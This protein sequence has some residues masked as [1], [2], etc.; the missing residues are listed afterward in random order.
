MGKL[1]SRLS[2][3]GRLHGNRLSSI[4]LGTIL[5]GNFQFVMAIHTGQYTSYDK[6]NFIMF[7]NCFEGDRGA[8][9]LPEAR[10]AFICNC[11]LSAVLSPVLCLLVPQ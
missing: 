9:L 1:H 11:C 6:I 5:L 7:L 4:L 8:L 3:T 10:H 2:S